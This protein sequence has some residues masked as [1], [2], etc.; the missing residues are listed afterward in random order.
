MSAIFRFPSCQYLSYTTDL[1]NY[2]ACVRMLFERMYGHVAHYCL[3][4]SHL[5]QKKTKQIIARLMRILKNDFPLNITGKG[6]IFVIEWYELLN[7][8]Y[9]YS[10]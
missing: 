10:R 2:R 4:I 1:I 5:I 3:L 6:L 8:P 9:S 7:K